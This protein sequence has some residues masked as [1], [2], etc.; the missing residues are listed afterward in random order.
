MENTFRTWQNRNLIITDKRWL[1]IKKLKIK[2]EIP[3]SKIKAI[4]TVIKKGRNDFLLHV[5]NDY[6]Y[7]MSY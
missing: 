2:R 5:E 1:N 3:I 7:K 6:D 4:T